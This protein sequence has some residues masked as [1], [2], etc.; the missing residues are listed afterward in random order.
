[1]EKIIEKATGNHLDKHQLIVSSQYGFISKTSC[2]TCY[3][4]HCKMNS[5]SGR[6]LVVTLYFDF[7][8]GFEKA[9]NSSLLIKPKT[10]GIGGKIHKWIISILKDRIQEVKI[11]QNFSD[12]KNITSSIFQG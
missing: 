9:Q 1:M 4:E 10:L 12:P 8:K 3:L 7:T 11:G 6:K 5:G 2:I